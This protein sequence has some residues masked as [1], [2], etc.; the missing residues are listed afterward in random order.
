MFL[1]AVN[2]EKELIVKAKG[3]KKPSDDDLPALLA[4]ISELMGKVTLTYLPS[5]TSSLCFLLLNHGLKDWG[6]S[7]SLSPW[8]RPF[9]RTALPLPIIP[10]MP[11]LPPSLS[12]GAHTLF[13]PFP[14]THAL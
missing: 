3:Q 11:L 1:K 9:T 13:L 5:P 6:A 12:S 8:L 14:V 2:A 4:P 7:Q 10:P